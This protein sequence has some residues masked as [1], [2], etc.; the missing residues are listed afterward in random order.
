MSSRGKRLA[1]SELKVG[2]LVLASLAILV[3]I[4]MSATGGIG[5]LFRQRFIAKTTFAE[6]DGLLPGAE[7][8]LAG[9]RVGNV[10][11]VNLAEVP[12]R[13]EDRNTV[14]VVMEIDPD[15][16]RRLI[17]SDSSATLGSIGLLGDKVVEIRPGTESG[18]PLP[19]GSYIQS[20]PGTDIRKIIS[21]VDPIISDLTATAE[22]IKQ[23]VTNINE[24]KGT[25]GQ[26]INNPR[27]YEH[28]D[29]TLL[30]ATRLLK[31]IRE[32][33]GTVGRLINDPAL[34]DD[35]RNTTRRLENFVRQIDE[36]QGTVTRLI[37]EP[38]L[39]TKLDATLTELKQTSERLNMI[40]AR[41][42][43]GE[44]TIG[45]LIHDSA[46]HDETKKTITNIQHITARLDQGQGTAGALLHDKALY[47]N[48]NELSS[49]LVR[50][51]YDFRQDPQK[52]LRLKISIF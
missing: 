1:W 15:I 28:L 35:L 50:L 52:Y 44:G 43:R 33:Q 26:L 7:V 21:G 12:K 30:E 13:A 38:Q 51:I 18:Q 11:A 49:Q 25:L 45:R 46:L 32:G 5:D 42:E 31:D 19:S 24:G 22:Q 27:A 41:I 17:R 10:K 2:L 9:K 16:A 14:E 47:D 20:T 48:L 4:I 36:G 6:V 3:F 37:K 39:Y 40:A 29:N 34:Y 23:L 8:R